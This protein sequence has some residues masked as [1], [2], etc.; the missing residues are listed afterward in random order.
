MG[1]EDVLNETPEVPET[2][3]IPVFTEAPEVETPTSVRK[4]GL[5]REHAAREVKEVKEV[6][7]AKEA[8]EVKEVKEVKEE[9]AKEAPFT[10][11]EKAFLARAEDEKRK[12]QELED[13]FRQQPQAPQA[14][15]EPKTFWDDPEGSLKSFQNRLFQEIT[16][17]RLNTAEIVARSRYPDFEETLSG[18]DE[19]VKTTPGLYEKW[20]SSS[21]PADFAYKTVKSHKELQEAGDIDKLRAKIEKE[22][23][24]KIEAELKDKAKKLHDEREAI[25]QSLSEVRGTPGSKVM[26]NGPEPLE[27]ILKQ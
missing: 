8:K 5:E 21:D 19:M 17:T 11:R 26:W 13:R 6:K 25:P 4:K 9:K 16:K 7:E 24:I 20:I 3:Q 2:P 15:Q 10:D 27:S 12:R 23:R 22:T 1:I 18:F 14:P